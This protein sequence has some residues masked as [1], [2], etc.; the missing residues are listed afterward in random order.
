MFDCFNSHGIVSSSVNFYKQPK[1]FL[2]STIF[3]DL[4]SSFRET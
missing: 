2:T 1:I 4:E 3:T